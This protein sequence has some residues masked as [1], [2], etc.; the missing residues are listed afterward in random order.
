MAKW[1]GH[2]IGG[3]D[4]QNLTEEDLD[5]RKWG[6]DHINKSIKQIDSETWLIGG[7]VLHRS[8]YPSDVATWNDDSDKSSY[9]LT[10][11][12]T[13]LLSA[14]TPLDSPYIKLIYESRDARAIWSIGNS[15]VCKA[16][17]T[18]KGTTPE[19]VTL[20]FVRNQQQPYSFETPEVLH[21]AFASDRSFLF[22]QRLPGRTLE[23]AWPSLNDFWRR[24]YVKLVASACREMAEW[25]GHVIGG[26]D[27]QNLPQVDL[28]PT[29]SP[30]GA[31]DFSSTNLQARCEL[32]GMD[33]SDLVF[34]HNS[35]ALE[36]IIVE[37]EPSEKIGLI[38]F[39][40]A[41][42][43]PRTWIRTKCI[44]S[45]AVCRTA[46]VG[47]G[48]WFAIELHRELANSGFDEAAGAYLISRLAL[49]V[50]S[51]L[52]SKLQRELANSGWDVRIASQIRR[53][54]L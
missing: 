42:Y 49:L 33:C 29:L 45:P 22:H 24:R 39:E 43:F 16:A 36:S 7:H 9:T 34:S 46:E 12:P 48:Y 19:S 10:V 2:V 26:V 5:P 44:V 38:D 50:T 30:Q 31:Q 18:T 21:H 52:G 41:G 51:Q 35:L 11:A 6:E 8:P 23:V 32:L 13:P 40:I 53:I 4:D 20:N 15:V 25:K 3:V 28:L 14:T 17:Y 47:G 37:D 27:G 1:K 54:L